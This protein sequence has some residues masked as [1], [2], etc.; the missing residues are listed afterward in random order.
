MSGPVLVT[1][2]AGFIGRHLCRALLAQGRQVYGLDL[3]IPGKTPGL[4]AFQSDGAAPEPIWIQ[5]D[6]CLAETWQDLPAFETIFHLA[7]L[8][9]VRP[10]IHAAPAYL[11][12]NLEGV[13]QAL[14]ACLR[15]EKQA[16]HFI[17]ASSSS[18][19]GGSQGRPLK[20]SDLPAP[21]SPYAV[22]KLAAEML[23]QSYTRLY[24]LKAVVL[25]F[26]TVYGPGQRPDM[27]LYQFA[28][29]LEQGLALTLFEPE[30]TR[31]DITYI[32]DIINGMLKAE[33]WSRLQS[34]SSFE[35]FNL[36]SGHPLSV[37]DWVNHLEAISGLKAA[38]K[39]FLARPAGDVSETWADLTHAASLLGYTPS[40]SLS[41]GLEIFWNWFSCKGK[42]YV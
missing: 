12:C 30:T 37:S 41:S 9:G 25:R 23:I 26:F 6:I 27:A 42:V 39:C 19:Y 13:A 5:G 34:A 4:E 14:D 1:G 32:S 35:V 22:S 38:E 7:A 3:R 10:S 28:Q 11:R 20:E 33:A 17:F 8:T 21:C 31:R 24:P 16:P 29:A 36:G 2:A 18:I 15:Q 40:T